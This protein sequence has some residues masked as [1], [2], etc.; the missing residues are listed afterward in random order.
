MTKLIEDA[1]AVLEQLPKE[2][3][4]RVVRAILDYASHDERDE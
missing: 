4:E 2:R 1:I 3:Q